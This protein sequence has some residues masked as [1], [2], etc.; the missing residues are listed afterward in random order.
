MLLHNIQ[1]KLHSKI[2]VCH[3]HYINNLPCYHIFALILYWKNAQCEYK[4]SKSI[5]MYYGN[6]NIGVLGSTKIFIFSLRAL[7]VQLKVPL[8]ISDANVI[9]TGCEVYPSWLQLTPTEICW[10][11]NEVN[12]QTCWDCC[13]TE[14]K[15]K[16]K[17]FIFKRYYLLIHNKF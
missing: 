4:Q 14:Q 1:L 12:T 16:L 2:S 15:I 5:N 13:I 7:I 6:Y 10:T 17:Y 8:S 9:R 3:L 11:G